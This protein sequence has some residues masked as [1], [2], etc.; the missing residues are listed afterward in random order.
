MSD[1]LGSRDIFY[2]QNFGCFRPKATFPT[3]KRFI[4]NYTNSRSA[5]RNFTKPLSTLVVNYL[6]CQIQTR[7]IP[8]EGLGSSGLQVL[9]FARCASIQAEMNIHFP[10]RE[11][12]TT[13]TVWIFPPVPICLHC[14]CAEFIV[15]GEPLEKLRGD[16][17]KATNG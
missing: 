1:L 5:L 2:P 17:R 8:Q 3:P 12:L 9:Q 7:S 6:V 11:N 13:P 14:G 10:G 15:N 16:R 4:V